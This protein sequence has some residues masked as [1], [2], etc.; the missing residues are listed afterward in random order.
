MKHQA[1]DAISPLQTTGKD[2]TPLEDDLPLLEIDLESDRIS[3]LVNNN[4]SDD[5]TL[6]NAQNETY[7]DTPPTFQEPLV[8]EAVDDYCKA[9]CV[10]IGQTRSEFRVDQRGFLAREFIGDESG[11]IIAPPWLRAHLL[12]SGTPSIYC[13]TPWTATDVR[14]VKMH[15]P[16]DANGQRRLCHDRRLQELCTKRK[17]IPPQATVRAF[18]AYGP[19][20]FVALNI[21]DPLPETNQ[22]NQLK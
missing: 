3:V 13:R 14:H 1:G 9:A 22:D 4:N 10:C 11:Q 6:L 20:D 16:M 17:S 21:L 8:E 12:F 19:L 5:I 18:P 7:I 2:D 15:V